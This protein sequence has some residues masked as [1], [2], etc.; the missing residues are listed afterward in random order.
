MSKLHRALPFIIILLLSIGCGGGSGG[1]SG[2]GVP[3]TP[4]NN[5]TFEAQIPASTLNPSLRASLIPED[6]QVLLEGVPLIFSTQIG[7]I[8][9]YNLEF[10]DENA[11]FTELIKQGGG[12]VDLTVIV[13]TKEPVTQ[14]LELSTLTDGASQ[15]TLSV[16]LNIQNNP[17]EG[18]YTVEIVG[19]PG[20]GPFGA[21]GQSNKS[22]GITGI[23]YKDSS[24]DY[25]PLANATGVPYINTTIKITFDS[26]VEHETNNFKIVA[27][28]ESGTS[29]T[30]TQSDIDSIFSITKTEIG[31]TDTDV[32]YSYLIVTLLKDNKEG[33][34]FG[35]G[36]KYTLKFESASVRRKDSPFVKLRPFTVLSRSFTTASE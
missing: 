19:G 22:L 11:S 25:Y 6:I 26:I 17:T 10:S 16:S 13:G 4:A 20:V 9:V 5:V 32:A 14:Q 18:T 31:A 28:S 8:L 24:G 36:K 30:L 2:V 7:D 23:D 29:V 15:K 3:L 1:G 33:K 35:P 12:I 34:I 27:I 21:P